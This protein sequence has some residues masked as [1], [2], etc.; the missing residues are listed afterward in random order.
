MLG[1]INTIREAIKYR[2]LKLLENKSLPKITLVPN[3]VLLLLN[4]CKVII[5]GFYVN[6]CDFHIIK[7]LLVSGGT[8]TIL[9]LFYVIEKVLYVRS[10]E[11][12]K[13]FK[14]KVCTLKN[15]HTTFIVT[16]VILHL[17][18][19]ILWGSFVVF[20][21][22]AYWKYEDIINLTTIS[23]YLPTSP[24]FANLSIQNKTKIIGSTIDILDHISRNNFYVYCPFFPFTFC[25]VTLILEFSMSPLMAIY[26]FYKT[27]NFYSVFE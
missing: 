3:I 10:D 23:R 16:A 12:P 13:H 1:Q 18:L 19:N 25:F 26:Y 9:I 15:L 8:S 6:N 17:S 2:F 20:H 14:L 27:R 22:Y 11:D 24:T 5:G 7:F 21:T 4:I